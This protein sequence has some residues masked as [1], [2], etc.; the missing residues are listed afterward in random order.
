MN[1]VDLYY[2]AVRHLNRYITF[3]PEF[4]K[5]ISRREFIEWAQKYLEYPY[6]LGTDGSSRDIGIDCSH[7]VSR[8]LIDTGCMNMYFFRA[9]RYLRNMTWEVKNLESIKKWDLLFLWDDTGEIGH[10]AIILGI[11]GKEKYQILD[12]SG[13]STG[14]W[15]TTIREISLE[16][17]RYYI[18][19]PFFLEKYEA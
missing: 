17:E 8:V 15:S 16:W 12:A 13:P 9:A 10:V 2:R 6:V 11:L 1:S 19:V 4:Q 5:Q 14:I 7:L 18:G 3:T